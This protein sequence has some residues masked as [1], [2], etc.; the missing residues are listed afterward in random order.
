MRYGELEEAVLEHLYAN[1]SPH[2]SHSTYN[3]AGTLKLQQLHEFETGSEQWR[4][5][6]HRAKEEVQRAIE[7]LIVERLVKGDRERDDQMIHFTNL[8]LIPKGEAEAIRLKREHEGAQKALSNADTAFEAMVQ[9][10]NYQNDD[11]APLPGISIRP[12]FISPG[13]S[14][15][16]TIVLHQGREK[17]WKLYRS[18][19]LA[20]AEA[21]EMGLIDKNNPRGEHGDPAAHPLLK[22]LATEVK[23]NPAELR[24]R[25]FNHQ[26]D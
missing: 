20:W 6:I 22:A 9:A 15:E 10:I 24:T 11:P 4:A 5:K 16:C 18:D 3:L 25:G 2:P 1:P 26:A 13:F 12:S 21:Q 19:K 7:S 17:W 14:G 23:L 8:K